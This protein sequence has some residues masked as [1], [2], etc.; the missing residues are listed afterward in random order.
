[1]M[2]YTKNDGTKKDYSP[3]ETKK[4]EAEIDASTIITPVRKSKGKKKE[5]QEEA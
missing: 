4:E 2:F 3:P 5:I 1:M